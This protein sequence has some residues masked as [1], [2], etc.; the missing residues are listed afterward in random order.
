[1]R[2]FQVGWLLITIAIFIP[3]FT[4]PF[5]EGYDHKVGFIESVHWMKLPLTPDKYLPFSFVILTS[6]VFA[7]TGIILLIFT[8]RAR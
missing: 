2:R 1:M 4:L 7:F 8:S 6:A 3:I 5:V